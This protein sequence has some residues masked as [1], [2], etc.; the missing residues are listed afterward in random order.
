MSQEAGETIINLHD[1]GKNRGKLKEGKRK[2]MQTKEKL[3]GASERGNR[4]GRNGKKTL[5]ARRDVW[6]VA[7]PRLG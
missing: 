3:H 2:K 5:N 7:E 4:S 6:K 1:T